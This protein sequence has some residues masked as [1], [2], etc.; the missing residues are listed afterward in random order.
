M[1]DGG[2]VA[3][4]AGL[5]LRRAGGGEGGLVVHR[6][7]VVEEVEE[8]ADGSA[9]IGEAQQF[10]LF[11][12]ACE[13]GGEAAEGGVVPGIVGVAAG[14]EGPHFLQPWDDV[15]WGGF[16]DGRER[17]A[18][19]LE[20]AADL[21]AAVGT[22]QRQIVGGADGGEV[23]LIDRGAVEAGLAAGGD[24]QER[25]VGGD[26]AEAEGAPVVA[27]LQGLEGG[28]CRLP[29]P[30]LRGEQAVIF[31][32]GAV[33]AGVAGLVER[34]GGAAAQQAGLQGMAEEGERDVPA[35]RIGDGE[36]FGA[37]GVAFQPGAGPGPAEEEAGGGAGLQRLPAGG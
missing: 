36:Q 31:D 22:E 27:V 30:A 35:L 15:R 16:G 7:A 24:C 1:G 23:D 10:D 21:G 34:Q 4:Q 8:Q 13:G 9:A 3:Q 32:E 17:A 5:V 2:G 37:D 14:V 11:V 29:F 26:A 18:M 28:P 25:R 12:A 33:G 6:C 20:G 19:I